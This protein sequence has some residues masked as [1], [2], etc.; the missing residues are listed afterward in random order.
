MKV[1]FVVAG[2]EN[3]GVEY[4]SSVL[5]EDGHQVSLVF[6]PKLFGSEAIQNSRLRRLFDIKHQLVREII[7]SAPDLIAFSVLTINYQ[8][9][10]EIARSLKKELDT[11]IIF[12]G[13]HSTSV[14]EAVL[15]ND[16]VD[17]V[18]VG[19]SEYAL[20]ELV[21]SLG[22]KPRYDIQNI[23]FKRNGNFVRNDIGPLI[24]D[25]DSLPLPDKQLFY[26]KQP[27]S[28]RDYY[29]MASR[30]CPFACTYC[31]NNV[32]KKLYQGKGRFYRRRSVDHVMDELK[33]AK[34]TFRP[35]R[36]TFADDFFVLDIN[37]LK[38]FIPRYKNEIDL[39]FVV[40]SHPNYINREI[41]CLLKE[42]GCFWIIMGVQS[43]SEISRRKVLKRYV[44]NEQI[45]VAAQAC[46]DEKMSFSVDHIFNIPYEG[47]K[48]QEEALSF[49]N[50]IRPAAINAYW[51]QYF[52]RAE[53]VDIAA[54]ARIIDHKVIEKVNEGKASASMVIGIGRKDSINLQKNFN[55]FYFLFM[56]LPLLP[57]NVVN[58]MIKRKWFLSHWR[59][60]LIIGVLVKFVSSLGLGRGYVYTD[61]IKGIFYNIFRNLTI[62]LKR[63]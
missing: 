20:L 17:M 15:K 40:M 27:F 1:T 45:I 60:P 61:M 44:S 18:C 29:I 43:V 50:T 35:R 2:V 26:S 47:T 56:I 24:E 38:K 39:P 4:L 7:E 22:G 5:K 36:I 6:D 8:W 48:E 46:H 58:K 19:E 9:A 10:L 53:I 51:L 42:G 14:P 52:P 21:D 32:L 33:W 13:I 23:W 3:M 63:T 54:E 57:K 31:C 55:N 49:Y 59:P 12:G 25:L 41:V 11:P 62:K 16:C 30:G 34:S 37:W 28:K